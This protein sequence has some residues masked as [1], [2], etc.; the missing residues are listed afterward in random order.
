MILFQNKLLESLG[1]ESQPCVG[2]GFGDVV[3]YELLKDEKL[4]PE[5][6]ESVDMVIAYMDDSSEL[7][8]VKAASLCRKEGLKVSL[9]LQAQKPKK[10]F[11]S[12]NKLGSKF[13]FLIGSKEAELESGNLKNLMTGDQEVVTIT[14]LCQK[15]I[16]SLKG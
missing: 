14:A 12:A 6:K 8:A 5:K 7:L 10:I 16:S 9:G 3:I 13:V 2:L 15:I 1:G 4:L 11:A